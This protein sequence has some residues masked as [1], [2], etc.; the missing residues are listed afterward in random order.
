[1]GQTFA[2]ERD[3]KGSMTMD[4]RRFDAW[5]KAFTADQT[6]R[7]TTLLG[8]TSAALGLLIARFPDSADAKKRKKKRKKK[9]VLNEFGCVDV[10][11][12]CRGND[13]NCCSGVCQGKK[14]KK[15][16]KDKSA[17]VAHNTGGCTLERNVCVTGD[18]EESACGQQ[19]FTVCTETTGSDAFCAN[20]DTAECRI[21]NTDADCEAQGF[22]IGSACI[23]VTGGECVGESDCNGVNGSSGTACA[24]PGATD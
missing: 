8:T 4:N 20:I 19:R 23:I 11:G 18:G 21:C 15:G 13:G 17:C 22:P 10:G 6:N 16:K 2:D 12:K 9:L 5:T 1:V 7:R 24:G 3:G 14:P